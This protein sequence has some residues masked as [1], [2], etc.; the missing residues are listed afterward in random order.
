MCDPGEVVC[1]LGFQMSFATCVI[2]LVVL[3]FIFHKFEACKKDSI[4]FEPIYGFFKGFF[5]FFYL[6]VAVIATQYLVNAINSNTKGFMDIVKP[7]TFLGIELLFPIFQLLGYKCLQNEGDDI[8][9]K[10]I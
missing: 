2:G 8:W 6:M 9:P 3:L 4:K 1:E 5:R 10:W 7:G